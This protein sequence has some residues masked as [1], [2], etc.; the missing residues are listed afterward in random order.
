MRKRKIALIC[1]CITE[2][3]SGERHAPAVS[4]LGSSHKIHFKKGF[5]TFVKRKSL[6][7]CTTSSNSNRGLK[8]LHTNLILGT[9]FVN[10]PLSSSNTPFT[11]YLTARKAS[12]QPFLSYERFTRWNTNVFRWS[13]YSNPKLSSICGGLFPRPQTRLVTSWLKRKTFNSGSRHRIPLHLVLGLKHP[14]QGTAEP[15]VTYF[16]TDLQS[17]SIQERESQEKKG[18]HVISCECQAID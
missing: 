3:E 2:P 4:S 9:L 16:I 12:D 18:T 11:L 5:Q 1:H 15:R 17:W 13:W 7:K 14:L 6:G 10:E 8:N